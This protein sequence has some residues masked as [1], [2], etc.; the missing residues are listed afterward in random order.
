MPGATIATAL[1][2]TAQTAGVI[3]AKL[4][5]RPE[6]AV[7]PTENGAAPRLTLLNGPNVMLCD[8]GL[9]VKLCD[10]GVAAP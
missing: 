9:T 7:A 3:E 10:T 4:T 2:A 6:V 8:P 5:A 1:P